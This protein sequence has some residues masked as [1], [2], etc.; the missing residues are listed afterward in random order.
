MRTLPIVVL[1]ASA[2]SGGAL[3][4]VPAPTEAAPESASLPS[5]FRGMAPRFNVGG[6]VRGL[7]GTLVLALG[8]ERQT[9]MEDGA[10]AFA[11]AVEHGR[12]Y[13]VSIVSAP[14][15]QSC[16]L[17]NAEGTIDA[18]DAA[19]VEVACTTMSEEVPTYTIAG[20]VSGLRGSLRLTL[21]DAGAIDLQADG[22]FA[23]SRQLPTG[24][25]YDVRV[26]RQ[27]IGQ[28]CTVVR[29]G[30]RV[31]MRD[32]ANISVDC[33]DVGC[34]NLG[35]KHGASDWS[36]PVGYRMPAADEYG[37]VSPCVD[38]T[39]TARFSSFSDIATAVGG[40]GCG[41]NAAWCD[42]PS[43]ETMR[44]GAACGDYPQ[45]HVCVAE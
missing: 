38:A 18:A 8:G 29:G 36:C 43:I 25:N 7:H 37:L 6:F 4:P 32:V 30:G 11:M 39:D 45:L 15:D 2:C 41:W 16:V 14:G 33:V 24:A 21:N 1:L 9:I 40:C 28:R 35:W 5:P 44:R 26:K 34:A 23:F 17:A 20:A 3:P 22:G 13:A 27:P 12:R 19:D 10:F 42:E 31:A